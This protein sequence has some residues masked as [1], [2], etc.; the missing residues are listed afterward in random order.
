MTDNITVVRGHRKT[1]GLVGSLSIWVNEPE[2]D[3]TRLSQ[4]NMG[5]LSSQMNP[6]QQFLQIAVCSKPSMAPQC[7][8][9]KAPTDTN[10]SYR[11]PGLPQLCKNHRVLFLLLLTLLTD[12]QPE[13]PPTSP[14]AR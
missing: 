8:Q 9:T 2:V 7:C 13:M 12:P 10:N 4:N 3:A 5:D 14:L 6:F 1:R 11:V